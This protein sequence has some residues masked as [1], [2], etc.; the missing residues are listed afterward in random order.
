MSPEGGQG[1]VVTRLDRW[2][3]FVVL[4]VFAFVPLLAY[5]APLGFAPLAALGGL[6][7]LPLLPRDRR[8]EAWPVVVIALILAWMA[9]S[10][11][12]SPHQAKDLTNGITFKLT[13]LI[14]LGLALISAFAVMPREA[15]RRGAILL[16]AGMVGLS[17]IL[18]A[19]ALTGAQIYQALKRLINEPIRPDLARRNIAQGAY[20]LAL[21]FWPAAQAAGRLGWRIAAF[22]IALMAVAVLAAQRLLD[23]DAPLFALAAGGVIWMAVRWLG[24]M[25]VRLLMAVAVAAFT[26]APLLMLEGVRTGLTG[27]LRNGLPESWNARLDIWT[28]VATQAAEHPLRGWGVDASRTFGE[29]IPL[30]PHNAAL[31]IWLELGAPGAALAGALIGWIAASL[32]V[33][34]RTNPSHAAAGAAALTAYLVIGALSFGVWQEWWVGLGLLTVATLAV[35]RRAWP[36][37]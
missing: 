1:G 37:V 13:L 32:A 15:A 30:H 23:A 9:L 21:M 27:L 25:A 17:L 10:T 22:P 11:L 19:D 12:W 2:N 20:V 26:L 36:R 35:V 24:P 28:Y 34:A 8:L 18:I 29:A 14:A 4:F 3:G 16:A 33:M 31:Q 5:L 6:M 7:A